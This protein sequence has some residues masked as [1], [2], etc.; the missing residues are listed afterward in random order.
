MEE[1]IKDIDSKIEELRDEKRKLVEKMKKDKHIETCTDTL[2]QKLYNILNKKSSFRGD[3]A[4]DEM[5]IIRGRFEHFTEEMYNNKDR[6]YCDYQL[7]ET[8]ANLILSFEE[9][10]KQ[11]S[12]NIDALVSA[13]KNMRPKKKEE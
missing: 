8:L 13:L 11:Y 10:K 9:D 6:S 5:E 2:M 7:G 1:K 3:L 12:L 4:E